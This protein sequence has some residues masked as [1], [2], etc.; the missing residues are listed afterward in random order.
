MTQ[1][2]SPTRKMSRE[3]ISTF[4]IVKL[5]ILLSNLIENHLIY[6]DLILNILIKYIMVFFHLYR[7]LFYSKK[8]KC[9]R[10]PK[11]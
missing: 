8:T 7:R 2:S 11:S 5:G 4:L 1:F 10:D 3:G 6:D 9:F